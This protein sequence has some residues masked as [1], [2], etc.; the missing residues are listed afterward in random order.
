MPGMLVCKMG[1]STDWHQLLFPAGAV[2]LIV[3][4]WLILHRTSRANP[5]D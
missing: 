5:P 1:E 2:V 3:G 4:V